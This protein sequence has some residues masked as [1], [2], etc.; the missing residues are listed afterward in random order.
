MTDFYTILGVPRTANVDEIKRAYRRL[1]SQH[2]PDKGGDVKKFQEIEE[3]YRILSD[4][5]TRQQYDSPRP[6]NP[7]GGQ[8]GAGPAQ[9]PFDFDAIF[10]MFGARP[11]DSPFHQ[12]HARAARLNLWIS[13]HDVAVGGNRIISVGT[14]HG[15]SNSEIAIPVGIEDGDTVR[16]AGAGPMGI[17]LV[18]TFKVRPDERWQRDNDVIV[19]NIDV[20]FWNLILGADV[21]VT[22][23]YGEQL[24]IVVPPRTQPSTMLRV[25]G[26]GLPRKNQPGSRTD[27]L[28]RVQA[29]LPT[30]I[31][32]NILEQIRLV[33]GH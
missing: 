23:I 7:F 16:Y 13:L 9:N 6:S 32:D 5:A 15:Q 19:T 25:R 1:A 20:D 21:D 17:D 33:R 28:V 8:R 18:I 11:S 12:Q 27:M 3:A 10:S 24:A 30:N 29:R 22:N 2:H 4:P 31:P 26:H 14:Q